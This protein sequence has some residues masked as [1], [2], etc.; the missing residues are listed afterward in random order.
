MPFEQDD[1]CGARPASGRRVGAGGDGRLAGL[2]DQAPVAPS[3]RQATYAVGVGLRPDDPLAQSVVQAIKHG[4]PEELS[5]LL[6]AH[7]TLAAEQLAGG[8]NAAWD[9]RTLLHV[10]TDW[11]GNVPGAGAKVAALAAAGADLDA[12]CWTPAPT[13][14]L[15]E[16]SSAAGRPWTMRSRSGSGR[17]RGAWSSAVPISSCGT[18]RRSAS[19]TISRPS[20]MARRRHRP[21][22][23]TNAF[24][25]ACHGGQ[26][27]RRVP[28][29]ARR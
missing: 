28:A 11:P 1:G 10:V 16:R 14:T 25:C 20:S 8:S 22:E 23:I 26:R 19:R 15:P 4:S 2:D 12:R 18:R 29:L 3:S 24:W 6:D 7:P 5:A 21:D 13:S 17:R 27:R 9:G